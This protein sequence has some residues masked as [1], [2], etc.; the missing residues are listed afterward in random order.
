MHLAPADGAIRRIHT[1]RELARRAV[2]AQRLSE[3]TIDPFATLVMDRDEL[4]LVFVNGPSRPY[5]RFS[6]PDQL[7]LREGLTR[8]WALLVGAADVLVHV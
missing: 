8:A 7:V 3:H 5:E 2:A 4:E 6:R 1:D